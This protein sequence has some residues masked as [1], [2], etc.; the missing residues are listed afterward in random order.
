MSVFLHVSQIQGWIILSPPPSSPLQKKNFFKLHNVGFPSTSAS[1][2]G[3]SLEHGFPNFSVHAPPPQ[4][5]ET[6]DT[7][8]IYHHG[9]IF[10]EIY[11]VLNLFY[12]HR[13]M[14]YK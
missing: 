10:R 11:F 7:L 4:M 1:A 5:L 8:T 14:H 3:H 2:L 12:T 6:Q 13:Y 9:D